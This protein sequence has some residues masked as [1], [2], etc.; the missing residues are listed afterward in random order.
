M[1]FTITCG[2]INTPVKLEAGAR[3]DKIE[4]KQMAPDGGRVKQKIVSEKTGEEIS[5]DQIRKAAEIPGEGTL[6][7]IPESEL[8]ALKPVS[9]K[10]ITIKEFVPEKSIDLVYVGESH[11]L[12]PDGAGRSYPLLF[13]ALRDTGK[14]GLGRVTMYGSETPCV[15]RAG[16][17][18]LVLHQLYYTPE[19][20]EE[21]EADVDLTLLDR[22]ELELAKQLIEAMSVPVFD[23]SQFVDNYKAK[24]RE[25]I[26]SK[27]EAA[28]PAAKPVA[29][30]IMA[31]MQATLKMLGK[32]T[33]K[34]KRKTEAA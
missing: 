34:R 7:E 8:E 13:A 6:V 32:D 28:T 29:I 4:L 33:P 26:Q 5:R 9:A 20:R 24:I 17:K 1:K 30:D 3:K 14:M 31:Q 16:R 25:L 18:G 23:S 15:I 21:R 27:L 2:L 10:V 22:K 12:K 11:Y 19:V